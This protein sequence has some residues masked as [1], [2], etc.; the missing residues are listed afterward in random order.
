MIA[1]VMTSAI[2]DEI[3]SRTIMGP[4]DAIAEPLSFFSLPDN[5]LYMG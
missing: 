5:M 2:Q 1:L 4:A 3:V